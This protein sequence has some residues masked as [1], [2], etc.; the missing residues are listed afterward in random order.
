VQR[1]IATCGLLRDIGTER[2]FPAADLRG[3]PVLPSPALRQAAGMLNERIEDVY[4]AAGKTVQVRFD[5]EDEQLYAV[6]HATDALRTDRYRGAALDTEAVL[7]LR[8]LVALHDNAIERAQD[9]FSG[10]TLVMTV[11]R[12]GL[13]VQSL[14]AWSA[15]RDRSAS[16]GPRDATTAPIV[17]DMLDGLAD[18]HVRALRMALDAEAPAFSVG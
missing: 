9:G 7:E 17:A 15:I 11:A 13:L 5:L 6:A 1:A 2:G 14:Q 4:T 3:C 16:T 8:E 12:L 18:V 10:G